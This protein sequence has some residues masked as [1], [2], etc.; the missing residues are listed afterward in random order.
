M[1]SD[2]DRKLH[3]R[4]IH[5]FY[6]GHTV[7]ATSIETNNSKSYNKHHIR[8]NEMEKVKGQP[9][10]KANGGL[11]G[12]FNQNLSDKFRGA[13]LSPAHAL[14]NGIHVVFPPLEVTSDYSL[15]PISEVKLEKIEGLW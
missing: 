7:T 1:N 3:V 8:N 5:R 4:T 9:I 12:C 10:S 15:D 13:S 11:C 2:G 6:D 14:L